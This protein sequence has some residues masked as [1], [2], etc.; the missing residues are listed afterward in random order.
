MD[1]MYCKHYV[2]TRE[3]GAIYDGWSDGVKPERNT[4][5]AVC[6]NERGG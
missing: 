6:I 1:E 2:L 3:D 4:E 5:N